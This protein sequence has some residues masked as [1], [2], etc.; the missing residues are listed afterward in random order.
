MYK[1]WSL[2][3]LIHFP[4]RLFHPRY[5]LATTQQVRDAFF[6]P[7]TQLHIVKHL[8]SLLSP[9][10][11]MLW[12]MQALFRFVSGPDVI[13]SIVGWTPR[14]LS[15]F[16]ESPPVKPRFLVLAGELDVLCTPSILKDAADRYNTA[17]RDCVK[18]GKVD[19]ISDNDAG[20][21]NRGVEFGVV[22][23]VGHHM[24][25]DGGWQLGA[26]RLIAW[27]DKL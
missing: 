16:E 6:T 18:S 26:M 17:F 2:T 3:A 14:M 20:A 8:E 23:G 13:R 15:E 19:G 25:N 22:N 1:F 10:E 27:A 4:Y 21:E 24:Q 7:I 5:I 11:S 9:Y 12:P